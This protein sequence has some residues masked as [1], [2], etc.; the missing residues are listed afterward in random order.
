MIHSLTDAGLNNHTGDA[1][2]VFATLTN[3]LG[4]AGFFAD[5]PSARPGV[6]VPTATDRPAPG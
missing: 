2:D 6:V 4:A 3:W 1:L 5:S